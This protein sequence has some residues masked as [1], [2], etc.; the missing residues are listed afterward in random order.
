MPF[1]EPIDPKAYR[2]RGALDSAVNRPFQTFGGV[3]LHPS[4]Y[5]KAA[6]LFHSLACNHCFLN[7]NKRTAVMGVDMFLTAN[8]VFLLINNDDMYSLAKDTVEAKK[9]GEPLDS[10][11]AR[12]VARF[13]TESVRFKAFRQLVAK[14]KYAH[15]KDVYDGLKKERS[16]IRSHPLNQPKGRSR[17]DA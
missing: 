13:E 8:E 15:F 17:N 16:S 2:D 14:K 4:I 11:L 9:N 3:D 5:Q 6:A 1:D 7:G 12:L 10:A